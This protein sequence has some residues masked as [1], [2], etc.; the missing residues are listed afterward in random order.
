MTRVRGLVCC[1]SMVE[2]CRLSHASAVTCSISHVLR[3]AQG[4]LLA[5]LHHVCVENVLERKEEGSGNDALR[6][7]W[8]N[9]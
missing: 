8:P 4:E 3:P 7:L 1:D 6:D 2:V 9:T 5:C